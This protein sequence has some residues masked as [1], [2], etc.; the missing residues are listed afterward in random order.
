MNDIGSFSKKDPAGHGERVFGKVGRFPMLVTSSLVARLPSGAPLLGARP[1]F[2]LSPAG[3]LTSRKCQPVMNQLSPY[4]S[5]QRASARTLRSFSN[6]LWTQRR[7]EADLP[8]ARTDDRHS[9]LGHVFGEALDFCV[10]VAVRLDQHRPNEVLSL[11]STPFAQNRGLPLSEQ[12]IDFRSHGFYPCSWVVDPKWK[13]SICCGRS[14][15]ERARD[16][17][18]P[19]PHVE[20]YYTITIRA[21]DATWGRST[22]CRKSTLLWEVDI[23]HRGSA[24]ASQFDSSLPLGT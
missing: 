7:Q 5:D 19:V 4:G 21:R 6:R 10:P 15:H 14:G 9:V 3:Q 18:G 23:D 11:G 22:C 20:A 2:C 24:R 1:Q 8:V 17:N 12:A 16:T 13:T